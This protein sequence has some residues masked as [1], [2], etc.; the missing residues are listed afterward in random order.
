[1]PDKH[2]LNMAYAIECP[3]IVSSHADELEA[4]LKDLHF[5]AAAGEADAEQQNGVLALIRSYLCL[6]KAE[7]QV[8]M[9]TI[10]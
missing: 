3:F 7:Q 6:L 10:F 8:H 1:M 4:T 5:L 2:L 9:S